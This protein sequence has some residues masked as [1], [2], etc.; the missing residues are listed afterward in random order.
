V[1]INVVGAGTVTYDGT[2]V[3]PCTSN[4]AKDVSCGHVR[5]DG[6][7][8]VTAAP[9]TGWK[10]EGW[11]ITLGATGDITNPSSATQQ[12][13]PSTDTSLTVTF[14]PLVRPIVAVFVPQLFSTTY[15]VDIEN[16]ALDIIKVQ[17]SGPG[18]GEWDPQTEQ[19]GS[20]STTS[21]TMTWSHP[22]PPCDANPGH[23]GTTI[24]ATIT[25][26][27]KTFICEYVGAESGEGLVCKPA[28]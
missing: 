18:C 25:I 22:H 14:V 13:V 15:R 9:A 26:K 23:D 12:I 11:S 7:G 20:E 2:A 6:V 21:F 1:N 17:W 28:E 16:P 8:S 4:G 10:L 5:F 24:R 3:A 27:D 19:L